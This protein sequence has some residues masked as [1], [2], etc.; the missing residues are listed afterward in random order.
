MGRRRIFRNSR[1]FSTRPDKSKYTHVCLL[2]WPK[3][4]QGLEAPEDS[5]SSPAAETGDA[6]G[7]PAAVP[8]GPR[9]PDLARASSVRAG[10]LFWSWAVN[11]LKGKVFVRGAFFRPARF[12]FLIS[13]SLLLS[14]TRP[15]VWVL[16][17]G[18]REGRGGGERREPRCADMSERAP[19]GREERITFLCLFR[20]ACSHVV[21]ASCR[22]R[23]LSACKG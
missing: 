19:E 13:P 21:C 4:R 2:C 20:L 17:G 12:S 11:G 7:E 14:A 3:K 23:P 22:D 15:S 16:P 9:R 5:A 10:A 18:G 8:P 6:E 1:E